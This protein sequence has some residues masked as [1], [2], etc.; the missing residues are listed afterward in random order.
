MPEP[1]VPYAVE[2]HPMLSAYYADRGQRPAFVRGLFNETAPYYDRINQL[3]SLGSG[4]WYRRHCLRRAGLRPGLRVIDIAAGTGLVAA[5][6]VG[7]TGN[8]ADVIGLDVSEAMLAETR[9]ALDIPLIQGHAERLPLADQSVDFLSMGYALRHISDLVGAFGEFHR[10]L[11]RDGTMLL[12][13]IS[14][15]SSPLYH[16]IA[17]F[18]LGRLVP[19]VCRWTM[20]GVGVQTLMRYYWDTIEHCVPPSV[21]VQAMRDSGFVD[22]QCDAEF[23]FFRNYVGRKR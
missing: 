13:E 9:R 16:K 11:R 18:Y 10:V 6:A 2:P 1:D 15:P 8:K 7:I 22:I 21:I 17:S 23:G 20:G 14:K 3:F 19:F 5:E 4:A 12:L